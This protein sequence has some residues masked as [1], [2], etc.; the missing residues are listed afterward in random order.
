[1]KNDWIDTKT[2]KIPAYNERSHEIFFK[3]DK[4]K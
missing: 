4:D 3:I 2:K 1:M